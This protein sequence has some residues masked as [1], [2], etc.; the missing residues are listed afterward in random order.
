MGGGAA[1]LVLDGGGIWWSEWG[2]S[3]TG[4]SGTDAGRT[5]AIV[6]AGGVGRRMGSPTPKQFLPLA[7]QPVL[8]HSLRV[9][10]EHPAVD[11]LAV[12]LDEAHHETLRTEAPWT[13]LTKPLTLAAAGAERADSVRSALASVRG[14]AEVVLIH[15]AAR[16]LVTARMIDET[17]AHARQGRGAIVARPASDTVK[18]VDEEQQIA[19][20]VDR[21]ALWLA[22]TP[23]TFPFD[24]LWRALE[25]ARERGLAVTD[26][27]QAVEAMG[28]RVVVCPAATPNPKITRPEDL[29]LV[30]ALLASRSEVAAR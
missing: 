18:R 8:W 1:A 22:E 29:A 11:A 7:G 14:A 10:D 12:A 5:V 26:D 3:E 9:F 20:T 21:A 24:L 23:Q 6:V 13:S 19:E 15:D 27:A 25:G 28:E 2:M 30:E 16:P 17:L 4:N